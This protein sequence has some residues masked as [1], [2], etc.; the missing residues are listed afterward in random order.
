M[1]YVDIYIRPASTALADFN[2]LPGLGNLLDSWDRLDFIKKS[3]K[4][5]IAP[6]TMEEYNDGSQGVAEETLSLA[7]ATFRCDKA[8]FEALRTISL[9]GHVDILMLDP[10]DESFITACWNLSLYVKPIAESD[11]SAILSLSASRSFSSVPD[12]SSVIIMGGLTPYGIIS[13]YVYRPGGSTPDSGVLVSVT[14]S[15]GTFSDTT[16]ADG[17]YLIYVNATAVGI[18]FTFTLTSAGKTYPT[19][20]TI[21]A[22][23]EIEVSKNFT[24]LT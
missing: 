4:L 5:E 11:D 6:K 19:G 17:Q 2:T 8:H 20:Q 12:I 22:K 9:A 16:D 24:A 13:G 18:T 1:R 3:P 10:A 21:L 23:Q 7:F 15:S 14:G